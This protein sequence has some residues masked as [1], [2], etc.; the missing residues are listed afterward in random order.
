MLETFEKV[1]LIRLFWKFFKIGIFTFGGGYAMIPLIEREVVEN[2]WI[3]KKD[4]ADI[5]AI[6]QSIPGAVAV[7]MSLFVGYKISGKKGAITAVFGCILPSFVIILV[8]ATVLS[9]IQDETIVQHAFIGILSA[10]VALIILSA[11]KIAKLAIL[12]KVTL[13]ITIITVILLVLGQVATISKVLVG[14]LPIVLIISG[15]LTGL[16][17]Y[18]FYPKKVRKL[19]KEGEDK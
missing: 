1:S 7:N 4:I 8:I 9:N 6:S 15:A 3:D 16:L 12:D 18:Y 13:L 2:K 11:I 5:V 17:I 19:F 14:L 10:V